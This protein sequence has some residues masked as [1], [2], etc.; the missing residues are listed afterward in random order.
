[1]ENK[2]ETIEE[3]TKE[4]EDDFIDLAVCWTTN[5]ECSLKEWADLII[6]TFSDVI[7]HNPYIYPIFS[8]DDDSDDIE[9]YGFVWIDCK[10]SDVQKIARGLVTN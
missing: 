9:G 1:M 7:D 8:D 4:V 5:L 3:L 6:P 10:F 2:D